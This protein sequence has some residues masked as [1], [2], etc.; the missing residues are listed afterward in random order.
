M[1]TFTIILILVLFIIAIAILLWANHIK[2]KK[3][4]HYK[5]KIT[6]AWEAYERMERTYTDIL[7]LK[8]AELSKKRPTK[9]I[10]ARNLI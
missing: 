2:E 6:K 4:K 9:K 1:I 5:L 8:E 10:K 3:I 7:N